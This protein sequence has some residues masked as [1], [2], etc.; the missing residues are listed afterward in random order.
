MASHRTEDAL[1]RAARRLGHR[2]EGFDVLRWHRRLG[3]VGAS[4][5]ARRLEA[6]HPDIVL[7][8][9]HAVRLGTDRLATLCRDR[10]VILWFFDTQP[11]PGV[12]EL[13]RACDEVY[14]T[15]AGL[16][17]T[18]REAGITS[19]RF[20]PQGVD[21]DLDRPGTAQPALACDIS[22]VGSGQYPYRWPLL[23][24]LAA[25]HDLQVRGP[26]WDAAPA[27]IPVVGGEVRG[28]AL[29]DI[30]TSAR[31]SLG[32]HAVPEQAGEYASASNRMWKILGAGG[33]YLGAWVPGIEHFAGDREHCRWYRSV[34]EALDACAEL[35]A[36]PDERRA[37]A[38]RGRAHALAHHSYD[39]RLAL[40]LEGSD[41][42]LPPPTST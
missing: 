10:R 1:V 27:G 39:R 29:A 34:E 35:L 3:T 23:E 21:P 11:Q 8:T 20:L 6:F 19:A 32:A 36:D 30:I 40:L 37:M 4:H 41:Y 28:P 22:F 24:R 12:L 9:R 13:A 38:E 16:V 7:C 31:I 2:A 18:W 14:L 5:V 15:Y 25:A 26:G 33:A 17:A 42:P